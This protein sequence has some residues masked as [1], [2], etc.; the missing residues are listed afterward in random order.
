MTLSGRFLQYQ[1][2][3]WNYPEVPA[4]VET[5]L[6]ISHDGIWGICTFTSISRW[7]SMSSEKKTGNICWEQRKNSIWS[8]RQQVFLSGILPLACM[9]LNIWFV[10]LTSISNSGAKSSISTLKRL[11]CLW[12]SCSR[13]TLEDGCTPGPSRRLPHKSRKST[14][15]ESVAACL[16]T[17]E[18]AVPQ[19]RVCHMLE[20]CENSPALKWPKQYYPHRPTRKCLIEDILEEPCALLQGDRERK[21]KK[22]NF[23]H[24]LHASSG[25]C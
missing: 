14:F 23:W 2:A 19:E 18:R 25:I 15:V 17:S 3:L 6:Y 10:S 7:D 4:S 9:V 16:V 11:P 12:S 22:Q 24:A 21:K 20:E 8:C 1:Q 13:R 5:R